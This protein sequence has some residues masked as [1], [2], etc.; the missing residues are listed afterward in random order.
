M[1]LSS[2]LVGFNGNVGNFKQFWVFFTSY[3]TCPF[4]SYLAI[5]AGLA[6]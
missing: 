5:C 4:A 1:N 2:V 3:E 6:N